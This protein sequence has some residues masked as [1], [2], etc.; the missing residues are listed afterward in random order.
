[1]GL[2]D[3]NQPDSTGGLVFRFSKGRIEASGDAAK[4][5]Q[6]PAVPVHVEWNQAMAEP[7]CS[8]SGPW[9]GPL[10]NESTKL[11]H[12]LFRAGRIARIQNVRSCF[13]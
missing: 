7:R 3:G 10:E 9:L 8:R 6:L 12:G 11:R 1:M 4:L 5:G 2:V 13:R